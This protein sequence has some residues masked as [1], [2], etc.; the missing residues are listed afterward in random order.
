MNDRNEPND[1]VLSRHERLALRHIEAEL[2]G[3]RRLARQMG[4]TRPPRPRRRLVLTVVI[5]TCASLLLAVMGIR[6][7]DPAVIWGFAALWPFT[8]LQAFRLLCRLSSSGDRVTSW[9]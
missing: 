3:D 9:L 8:L 4:R 2:S 7:S 5:L 6:T 1:I